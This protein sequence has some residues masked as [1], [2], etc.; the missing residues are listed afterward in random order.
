MVTV[1]LP[2]YLAEIAGKKSIDVKAGTVAQAIRAID[3]RHPGILDK[4]CGESGE[5]RPH[6]LI[7]VN[8]VEIGRLDG[9]KTALR[10]DET[11]LIL[12]AVSGG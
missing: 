7:F 4:I 3:R 9:L 2:H 1:E 6:I 10:G 8:D 11:I 12:P 5:I